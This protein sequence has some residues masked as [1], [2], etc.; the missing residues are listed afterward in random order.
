MNLHLENFQK[1]IKLGEIM[2]NKK[3]I[4]FLLS[5]VIFIVLSSGVKAKDGEILI[6]FT[7]PVSGALA[8]IGKAMQS[9]A[10]LAVNQAN[11]AGGV[12]VGGKTYKIKLVIGDTEGL[13]AER[14]VS[15]A[16]RLMDLEEVRGIVGFAIS[17]SILAAIPLINDAQVPLINVVGKSTGI[18]EKIASDRLEYIFQLS[19]TNEELVGSHG[20]LLAHH[21]KPKKA[22]ILTFNTDAA[23]DY[24][25]RAERL[26]PK[27]IGG[28]KMESYFVEG[29][30]MDLQ[31][32]LLKIRSF[33]PDVLYV[34]F[35][36]AQTY[37]FVDQFAAS[38]LGEKIVV[39]GDSEYS[40]PTFQQK[41]GNKSNLHLANSVTYKAPITKLTLPFYEA[42]KN[43]HGTYPPY[44]SVQTYDGMLMM[45]EGIRR[46]GKITGNMSKDRKAIRNGLKK[47]SKNNPVLATRGQLSFSSLETGHRVAADVAVIQYQN[48]N[49]KL[50]W[51]AGSG[52]VAFID[53]RK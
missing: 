32:E 19:P 20:G 9:A 15:A 7:G 10:Q 45:L 43:F 13:K 14:A 11:D 29:N 36:G 33:S 21:I 28:L 2:F 12:K 22:A 53:P 16:R 48:G 50:V 5:S 37:A 1:L 39:F 25:M 42:F 17:T 35:A 24:V 38:G 51:P 23:R 47:I 34:L 27:L 41:T 30:K 4:L 8:E 40:S 26:W 31:P 46:A 3:S 49:S 18:P 44:Y 52:S 6:G